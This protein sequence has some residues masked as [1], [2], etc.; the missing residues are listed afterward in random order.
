[1]AVAAFS[2]EAPALSSLLVE[3]ALLLSLVLELPLAEG[4]LLGAMVRGVANCEFL[5]EDVEDTRLWDLR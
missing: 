1:M 4:F 5:E 3:A 2:F